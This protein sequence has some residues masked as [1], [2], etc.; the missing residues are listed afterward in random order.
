LSEILPKRRGR[1]NVT[2]R[3]LTIFWNKG[4][5]IKYGTLT[6]SE[7]EVGEI[8]ADATFGEEGLVPCHFSK[9]KEGDLVAVW[10]RLE[11]KRVPEKGKGKNLKEKK[12]V[13]QG[14]KED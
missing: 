11:L 10:N 7:C 14:R 1:G 13:L 12:G 3:I 4:G 2:A 6:W 9:G 8:T 5:E